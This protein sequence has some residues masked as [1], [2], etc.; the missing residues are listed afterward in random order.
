MQQASAG[1][2][3]HPEP[4]RFTL[5]ASMVSL[6]REHAHHA[7]DSAPCQ[8]SLQAWP[9][10]S[11]WDMCCRCVVMVGMPYPN[12]ADPELQ[13]RMRYMDAQQQQHALRPASPLHTSHPP[14]HSCAAELESM[15]HKRG[16]QAADLVSASISRA[17]TA[18]LTDS[19]RTDTSAGKQYYEDLC[20]KA[21]N[22]CIGR[23][24]RHRNDYAAVVLADARWA[25]GNGTYEAGNS[26][27]PIGPLRKLPA[28]IQ[29][30][31]VVCTTFGDG[32]GRLH[33]F[34]RQMR[35]ASKLC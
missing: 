32:Y 1:F 6:H 24:I 8:G 2:R 26:C 15:T 22:Q 31:L 28:W 4:R 33:R 16:L 25:A 27:R 13:E 3:A 5:L 34:H 30:S 20:L 35:K 23:V 17:L 11:K 18:G 19:S 9:C 10:S 12:P 29:D 21:V 14:D 7:V